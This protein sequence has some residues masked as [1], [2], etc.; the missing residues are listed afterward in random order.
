MEPPVYREKW[1]TLKG[2]PPSPNEL[3]QLAQQVAYSFIGRYYQSGLYKAEYIELLCEMATSFP[4]AELNNRVSSA[5]FGIIVEQLCD[6]YEEMPV[7]TYSQVMSQAISYCRKLVE[8]APLDRRL[9]DFGISTFDEL[10]RR[11]NLVHSRRYIYG[12]GKSPAKVVLLSRVTIGADVAILSVMIQRLMKIFP[13]AEIVVIGDAKLEG[14]FGGHP[15]IRVCRLGYARSGGIFQRFSSWHAALDILAKEMPPENEGDIL[16]IDPDSR[17][18]QLGVLPFTHSDNY[19]FF[20]SRR[21]DSSSKNLCMAELANRW[22]DD[23]FGT[24]GFCYPMIWPPVPV[25]LRARTITEALRAAGCRRVVA[26]NFGVGTNPR[27]RLSDDFEEKLL[28]AI[29]KSPGTVVLLD[30]GAGAEE[31]SRTATLLDAMRDRGLHASSTGFRDCDLPRIS[32]GVVGMDCAIGEVAALIAQCDEFIG[33]DSACQHIAAAAKTPTLTIFAGSNNMHFIRRWSA[34][35]DTPCRI[36][37]VNTLADPAHIDTDAA[38]LR[39]MEE[40]AAAAPV[41][42]KR[43]QRILEIKARDRAGEQAPRTMDGLIE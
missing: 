41:G 4:D 35:G 9:T 25:R 20:N 42:M 33:Y 11:A 7:E 43:A 28:A 22:M 18:S 27:K 40:R 32:H 17:V 30:R 1:L 37:H 10:C 23:V 8:G 5:L 15:S 26:V 16:L 14:I 29:L 3:S 21:C 39:I 31:L 2:G 38:V 12:A 24:S 36:V 13:D 34:C 6:D 19:L